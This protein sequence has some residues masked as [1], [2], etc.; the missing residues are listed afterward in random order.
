[1]KFE[2]SPEEVKM[3]NEW[4]REHKKVCSVILNSPTPAIGGR[5]TFSF[6]PTGIGTFSTVKCICGE[7]CNLSDAVNF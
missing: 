6:T 5:L 7:T 2:L 1:M 3:Y 4:N